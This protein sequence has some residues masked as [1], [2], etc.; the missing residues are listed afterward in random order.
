[1]RAFGSSSRHGFAV[2]VMLLLAALG[3]I[4]PASAQPRNG[5]F[6]GRLGFGQPVG[7]FGNVQSAGFSLGAGGVLHATARLSLRADVDFTALAETIDRTGPSPLQHHGQQLWQYVGGL[8]YRLTPGNSAYLVDTYLGAGLAHRTQH[9]RGTNALDLAGGMRFGR[10]VSR[11]AEVALRTVVHRIGP[12]EERPRV[13]HQVQ[14]A[15]TWR[16]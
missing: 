15:A 13:V 10:T 1:M 8:G 14:L 5:A 12:F 6:E 16:R 3:S 7:S 11:H 9:N 2:A 4:S